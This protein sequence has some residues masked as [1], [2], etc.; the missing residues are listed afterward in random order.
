MDKLAGTEFFR[1]LSGNNYLSHN[2]AVEDLKQGDVQLA[3]R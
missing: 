1:S 3:A 2:Q